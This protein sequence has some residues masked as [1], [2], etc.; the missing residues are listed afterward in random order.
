MEQDGSQVLAP[1]GDR[2]SQ[3][4]DPRKRAERFKRWFEESHRTFSNWREKAIESY[5]FV[6]GDQWSDSDREKLQRQKRPALVINKILSPVMF[7]LGVQRQQR[8]EP[9]ILPFEASDVRP[10]ELM[11]AL[12]KWSSTRCRE[13]VVD[14]AVFSDKIITGLGYWKVRLNFDQSPEGEIW[15][16]RLSP[17]AVFPDPNFLDGGWESASYAIHAT[18]WTLDE[19][20]ERWPDHAEALERRHGEWLACGASTNVSFGGGEEAGDSLA[21]D[22]LFWDKDT[23]RIRILEVWYKQRVP[24]QVAVNQQTGDV[25]SD[26]SEIAMLM[27]QP[28][29]GVSIAERM[30]TGIRVAHVLDEILLDDEESPYREQVLPIFSTMGYYFWKT[31]FGIVEPMKDPQREKNRRRSTM[32]EMV[33][34]SSLSGFFNKREGGARNE[35]IKEYGAGSGLVINYDNT[36]PQ[37]ISPPELPQ[38]LVFLDARADQ[39]LRDVT[40]IHNEMLGNTSQRFVSGRAI[41]ARQRSGLTVQEPLLESFVQDKEPAVRFA[42]SLIQQF[43]TVPTAL[44]ILGNIVARNPEI[45][46]A[47]VIVETPYE[48]LR[49]LLSETFV[50]RYDAVVG[51]KPFEPSIQV[52]RWNVLAELAQTYQGQIPPDVLVEAARDAGLLSESAA[53]RTLAHVQK[54]QAFQ[55]ATAMA[56]AQTGSGVPAEAIS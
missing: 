49:K 53:A 55:D 8:Q 18:W 16:E 38:T 37:Q 36:P 35:D 9:K 22:R 43:M 29:P 41:E 5:K 26:R 32:V 52:Q 51:T 20:M 30:V 10:A 25:I 21:G 46:V 24:T 56:G 39:E 33:Q 19:A 11:S 1:V 40:N 34:R 44:R 27:Q 54:L 13:D 47:G 3:E 42:I 23:Q 6:S 31:P 7:L 48:E 2:L 4:D 12:Y 28:Q 50:A 15:W 17:L 14:S 45:P